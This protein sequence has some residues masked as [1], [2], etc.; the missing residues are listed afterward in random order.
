[1]VAQL[2]PNSHRVLQFDPQGHRMGPLGT[3]AAQGALIWGLMW[4]LGA[5]QNLF[6][7][8]ITGSLAFILAVGAFMVA[9]RRVVMEFP[10]SLSILGAY[11]ITIVSIIWTID[12][13]ATESSIKGLI[14]AMIG[15]M[16][17]GGLLTLRDL[18]NAFI[19]CIRI[20]IVITVLALIA[21]P[22]SRLHQG[23]QGGVVGHYPG[24]HGL[25]I[26]KNNMGA[27]MVLALPTVLVFHRPG[28]IKW[29]TLGLLGILL[30]GS[31]SA[32]GFTAGAFVVL[33]WIWLLLYHNQAREDA[34]NATL[35]FLTSVLGALAV[36]STAV[37]SVATITSAYGKD[38][39]FSGRTLI[40]EASLDALWREPWLGYG[41][42]AL[43]WLDGV[44]PETAEIWRQVGFRNSHAHNGPL[45]L[46]L[47]IGLVGLAI[48]MVLWVSI[49]WRGWEAISSQPDL[50][51]WTICFASS[52]FLMS[53]S[54][55]VFY[56]G[57]LAVFALVKMLLMRRDESLRR[58]GW[59]EQPID[60]WAFR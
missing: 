31:R 43:F 60:K 26:H 33:A 30:A 5:V 8:P 24:W 21:I 32:T 56:G 9:P 45:D 25:F 18:M 10:I 40:W 55:D 22:A 35:L 6:L 34:R 53:I 19:W 7:P 59:L 36:I 51:I 27:F 29:G 52:N 15:V 28:I 42:G 13:V 48:M 57:W 38:T 23:V 54:E 37:A 58:P 11:T 2:E 41:F 4:T 47:Q 17:V 46:A 14:P 12:R 3:L 50:G 16:M 20:V 44:S 1:M 39:T 49:V